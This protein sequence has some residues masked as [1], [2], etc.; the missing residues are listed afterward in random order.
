MPPA[1][2]VQQRG[3]PW[4]VTVNNAALQNF[5]ANDHQRRPWC[6]QGGMLCVPLDTSL[7]VIGPQT[8]QTAPHAVHN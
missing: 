8:Q 5:V 3:E 7:G 2:P 6:V 4:G 1:A